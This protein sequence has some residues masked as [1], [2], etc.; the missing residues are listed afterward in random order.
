[1]GF[2]LRLKQIIN[3]FKNIRIEVQT[4][5]YKSRVNRKKQLLSVKRDRLSKKKSVFWFKKKI[6][7]NKKSTSQ[8]VEF[9][10][11]IKQIL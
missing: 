6:F 10:E 11:K 2:F 7:E 3:W 4:V 9:K 1:M 5:K 8:T